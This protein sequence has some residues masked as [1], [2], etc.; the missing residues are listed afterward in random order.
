L[1]ALVRQTLQ[2]GARAARLLTADGVMPIVDVLAPLADDDTMRGGRRALRAEDLIREAL[3][4]VGG[5]PAEVLA[6]LLELEPTT[7]G[8]SLTRRRERAARMMNVHV[9][10]FQKSDRYEK[11]FV[12][13]LTLSLYRL[14]L[15]RGIAA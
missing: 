2:T 6:V 9:D 15:A 4:V 3:A 8:L 14:L 7:S 10:T 13:D 12:L 5:E 1:L 11:A